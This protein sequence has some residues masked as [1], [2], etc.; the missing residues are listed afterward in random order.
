VQ[1]RLQTSFQKLFEN[2]DFNCVSA[3]ALYAIICEKLDIPTRIVEVPQH[4]YLI[5][6][7]GRSDIA[8][9]ATSQQGG[10]FEFDESFVARAVSSLHKSKIISDTELKGRPVRELFNDYYFSKGQITLKEL[11]GLQY[12]N[13][14]LYHTEKGRIDEAL[15]DSKKAAF[16]FPANRNYLVLRTLLMQKLGKGNYKDEGMESAFVL[17][18]RLHYPDSPEP[19]TDDFRSEFT[20]I[21][22]ELM[23]DSY[24]PAK[25]HKLYN[26]VETIVKDSTLQK[27]FAF[28][29]H[30]ETARLG[31]INHEKD[32]LVYDHLKK[33]YDTYPDHAQLQKM[34][35]AYFDERVH[36]SEDPAYMQEVMNKYEKTFPFVTSDPDYN[37]IRANSC[38]F[39][40]YR[41]FALRES[42]LGSKKLAEFESIMSTSSALRSSPNMVEAAYSEAA[43]FYFKAGNYSKAKELLKKGLVYA[44]GNFGLERRLSAF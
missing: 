28:Q 17:L 6:Y 3:T 15:R 29:Y 14:A 35:V 33:A 26:T 40:A 2:G 21:T 39:M 5:A 4:V 34:I 42:S 25:Y 19:D 32:D 31:W 27:D 44:P 16:L 36:L 9:E 30:F 18:L 8:I 24:Q 11:A 37:S 1:Y 43:G 13:F 38:L 10:Y 7:P 20:R 22:D 23:I 41:H 12:S